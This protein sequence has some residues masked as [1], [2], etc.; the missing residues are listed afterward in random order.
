VKRLSQGLKLPA[1]EIVEFYKASEFEDEG[2]D[3]AFIELDEGSKTMGLRKRYDEAEKREAC[4]FYENQRCTVYEHRPVTCRVWPFSL[5]LDSTGKRLTKLEINDALPC[6]YELD[7]AN[8][9]EQ[10]IKN[11]AWDDQQDERWK[12]K[13]KNWN[14]LHSGQNRAAFLKFMGF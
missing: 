5:S 10:L 1:T 12:L 9:P 11:W 7:G 2:E 14:R 6:P 8:K 3:L 4:F 13:V